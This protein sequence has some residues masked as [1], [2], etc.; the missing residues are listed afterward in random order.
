[1]WAAS[2]TT[3]DRGE[4]WV[5][6]TPISGGRYR[7]ESGLRP[8]QQWS[9]RSLRRPQFKAAA[10]ALCE[11]TLL[12][13]DTDVFTEALVQQATAWNVLRRFFGSKTF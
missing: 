12:T 8:F 4:A 6:L 11:A 5:E 1:M 7:H 10:E 2:R 9:Q 3:D 13:P